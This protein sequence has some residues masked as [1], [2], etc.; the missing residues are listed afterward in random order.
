MKL[1]F[2]WHKATGE[3]IEHT[4]IAKPL[5]MPP[6]PNPTPFA[7]PQGVPPC[8]QSLRA[9]HPASEQRSTWTSHA[10]VALSRDLSFWFRSGLYADKALCGRAAW[11]PSHTSVQLIVNIY[12]SASRD[13]RP[14]SVH[15]GFHHTIS[16]KIFLPKH[17]FPSIF[18]QTDRAGSRFGT[19]ANIAVRLALP[20]GRLRISANI[21]TRRRSCHFLRFDRDTGQSSSRPGGE[22]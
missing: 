6:E 14:M 2:Q 3:P 11:W 12:C 20:P 22:R 21:W 10:V 13:Q 17:F 8:T 5:G 18:C 9:C 7:K 15:Q 16:Q 4:P 1:G 19:V